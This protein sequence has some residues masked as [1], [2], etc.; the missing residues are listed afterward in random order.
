MSKVLPFRYHYD[1][2]P[3]DINLPRPVRVKAEPV[4]DDV[5][6]GWEEVMQG[7]WEAFQS[8]AE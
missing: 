3:L 8:R 2:W 6:K 5:R 7:T 1:G 4:P